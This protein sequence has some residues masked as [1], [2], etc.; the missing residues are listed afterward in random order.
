MSNKTNHELINFV[1][2]NCFMNHAHT[3]VDRHSNIYYDPAN[4]MWYRSSIGIFE[5]EEYCGI[6]I[7]FYWP[8]GITIF[9]NIQ[10]FTIAFII[11]A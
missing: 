11:Y 2:L 3:I 7:T 6:S 4:V 1:S 9:D 5:Y 8:V 10:Y